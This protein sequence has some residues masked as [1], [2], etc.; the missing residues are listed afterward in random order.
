MSHTNQEAIVAMASELVAVAK[1]CGLVLTI[2]TKPRQPLAMGNYDM[3]VGLRPLRNTV[4]HSPADD[5]EG[6]EA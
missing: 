1:S 6:G 3:V 4:R 2:S 5:T